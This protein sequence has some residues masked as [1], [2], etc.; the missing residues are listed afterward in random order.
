MVLDNFFNSTLGG[1]INWNPLASLAII[2]F[3]LM[4]FTTLIYK[5]FTDQEALKSIKLEIKAIQNEMKEFKHDTQKVME[6]QK[7]SF[8]KTIETFKHQIKPMIIT[9]IPFVILL[10]W[11]GNAYIPH[12]KIFLGMG[13]LGNY[14]IL[15][16][17]FN[18][19]LRKLLR[20]H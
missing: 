3:V 19:G 2:S 16:I 7:K 18:I 10:P 12:G 20:V 6:L 14:L 1:L 13:W 9:F 4:L 15:S 11:L 8:Q 5:Y 17:V